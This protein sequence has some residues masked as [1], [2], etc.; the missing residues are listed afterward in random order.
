MDDS[1]TQQNLPDLPPPS[2]PE[3]PEVVPRLQAG[4]APSAPHDDE[5]FGIDWGRYIAALRRYKWMIIGI[6][7]LGQN[8]LVNKPARVRLHG[9]A[10]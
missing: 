6:T 2:S 3:V 10:V 1:P 8:R 7:A 5:E 4:L 9:G